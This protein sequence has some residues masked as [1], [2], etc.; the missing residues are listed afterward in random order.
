MQTELF[1]Y[2][3]EDDRVVEL[4]ADVPVISCSSCGERYTDDRAA[5]IRHDAVCRFLGRLTP[6]DLRKIRESYGYSQAQWSELTGIGIASIK[7]WESGVL[8]QGVALDRFIRVLSNTH[9]LDLLKN[10][11]GLRSGSIPQRTFRTTISA[12]TVKDASAFHLR[13]ERALA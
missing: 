11:S 6:S 5:D 8:I 7:R 2:Q 4:R 12:L 3:T 1:N 13:A 10:L 9:G